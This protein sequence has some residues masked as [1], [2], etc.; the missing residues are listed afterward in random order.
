M[1]PRTLKLLALM[2]FFPFVKL[3]DIRQEGNA[4]IV[5]VEFLVERPQE[6]VV[7]IEE[8]EQI[9]IVFAHDDLVPPK[10]KALR[11]SFPH[12]PHQNLVPANTPKEL[13]IF[14]EPYLEIRDR[15]TPFN[16]L[17]RIRQ[18]LARATTGELH[19]PGQPLEPFLLTQQRI[20]FDPAIFDEAGDEPAFTV[21]FRTYDQPLTL[22]A[23]KIDSTDLSQVREGFILVPLRA[24]PWHAGLIQHQPK[25]FYELAALFEEVQLNLDVEI[26]AYV[27]RL[28]HTPQGN[29]LEK[30]RL[31]LLL[32]LP[33]Q[34]AKD[35]EVESLEWWSFVLITPLGDIVKRLGYGEFLGQHFIPL[36]GS[37]SQA[38][39]DD[40]LIDT[41]MPIFTLKRSLAQALAGEAEGNVNIVVVGAGALGSH[42]ILNLGRQGF[43]TW[44][45]IDNDVLLPH[46][47][48]RHVLSQEYEG[49]NKAHALSEELNYLFH[50]T[51]T[52]KFF[53]QDISQLIANEEQRKTIFEN[54]DLILDYSA[55][56]GVS[57]FLAMFDHPAPRISAFLGVNGRFCV[58]FSEGQGRSIRL[59]D[60][61]MQFAAAIV[62][63]EK[64]W[65]FYGEASSVT[66]AG[67][68]RAVSTQMPEDAVS[69]HAAAIARF[70]KNNTK[71]ISPQIL[72]WEWS[73]N[74]FELRSQQLPCYPV[75]V[76]VIKG[77]TIR[78]SNHALDQMKELRQKKLPFETGGVLLGRFDSGCRT[79][80]IVSVLPSPQDS[81]EQSDS[82]RRG[83]DGLGESIG[84]IGKLSGGDLNYVGEWHSHPDNCSSQPGGID[85]AAHEVLTQE[86]GREGLPAIIAIQGQADEVVFLIGELQT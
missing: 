44:K 33:K 15:L 69:I 11:R 63:N 52:A 48:A 86:M 16:L 22:R 70:V 41:L 24:S 55:S 2:D 30:Y 57:N 83:K 12:T 29:Y 32:S 85:L 47:F 4:D 23:E 8:Y 37:T 31:I 34:R 25:N 79:V 51:N 81:V 20:I 80:Y 36:I 50:D 21:A 66:Y 28:I 65:G 13:C 61:Q 27:E 56:R 14:A 59:D 58:L 67:S 71:T 68:C 38:S 45:I 17:Q 62:E 26:R 43:G 74:T 19:Q 53:A 39:L 46:N 10:I 7:D 49:W 75:E 78:V 72:L 77:W 9:A 6:P 84:V 35:G 3:I 64:F 60:L 42:V 76:W 40:I 73:S 18:W 5:V 82:Y 1:T 54:A